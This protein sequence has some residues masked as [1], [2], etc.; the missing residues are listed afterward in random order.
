MA[1]SI[2]VVVGRMRRR[3][4][5]SVSGRDCANPLQ[6]RRSWDRRRCYHDSGGRS[7]LR[8]D[9]RGWKLR[10]WAERIIGPRIDRLTAHR[11]L[12]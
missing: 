3:A 5:A 2:R 9:S 11:Q 4:A 7:W 6:E 12:R 10:V 1:E 8:R